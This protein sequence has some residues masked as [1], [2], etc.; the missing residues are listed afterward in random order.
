MVPG[1]W[2]E[3]SNCWN[4]SDGNN[5]RQGNVAPGHGVLLAMAGP[6]LRLYAYRAEKAGPSSA[7]VPGQ[8]PLD[9]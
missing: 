7:E 5:D 4:N 8:A 9:S 2:S 1:G 6:L 3:K